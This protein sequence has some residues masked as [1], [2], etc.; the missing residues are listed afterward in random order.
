MWWCLVCLSCPSALQF[1]FF[2]LCQPLNGEEGF[3][4]H[5]CLNENKKIS[6]GGL[7]CTSIEEKHLCWERPES[8]AEVPQ[9]PPYWIYWDFRS[10]WLVLWFL[11]RRLLVLVGWQLPGLYIQTTQMEAFT[12]THC[13]HGFCLSQWCPVVMVDVW[14]YSHCPIPW[15]VS[16]T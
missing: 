8:S 10:T 3:P 1:V 5:V 9:V 11:E 12:S 14:L 16:S 4:A 15:A 7:A 2:V 13:G 6:T